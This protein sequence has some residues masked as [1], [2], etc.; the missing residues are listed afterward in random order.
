LSNITNF[1]GSKNRTTYRIMTNQLYLN[2]PMTF[3]FKIKRVFK[4]WVGHFFNFLILKTD[5]L[6]PSAN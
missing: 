3:F 6:L 4:L 5:L 2:V 1:I